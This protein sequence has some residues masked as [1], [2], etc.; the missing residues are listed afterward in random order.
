MD[1]YQ[2][3]H[4]Y[5][6]HLFVDVG[7]LLHV[8]T[9]CLVVQFGVETVLVHVYSLKSTIECIACILDVTCLAFALEVD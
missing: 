2:P 3:I 1:L 9:V 7:L 4:Q 5:A 8:V 6:A